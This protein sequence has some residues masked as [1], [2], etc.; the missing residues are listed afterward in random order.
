MINHAL[1][2]NLGDKRNYREDLKKMA[3]LGFEYVDFSGNLFYKGDSKLFYEE[4]KNKFYQIA[5][6]VEDSGVR[7]YSVHLL[8]S[9]F[10]PLEESPD[11]VIQ[12]NKKLIELASIM[13]PKCVTTHICA[14]PDLTEVIEKISCQQ[15]DAKVIPVY[16]ELCHYASQY[17]ITLTIENI[18]ELNYARCRRWK[19]GLDSYAVTMSDLRRLINIIDEPNLGIC[20][21]SGHAYINGISP[22]EAIL[23]AGDLLRQTH[24]N[25]NFGLTGNGMGDSD[26]HLPPGLGT[27]NWLE[28][29]A[30]LNQISY[31][32]PIMFET[33]GYRKCG[34]FEDALVLIKE[35]WKAFVRLYES[36]TQRT[37][38][39]N[40]GESYEK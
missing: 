21:D 33:G 7:V 20:L 13:K 2:I 37:S 6:W 40:H 9:T 32:N 27:I 28:V 31:S 3:D 1:G 30:A 8:H 5:Q 36:I 35:N 25:D 14:S 39:L 15:F 26:L 4:D 22:G 11:E 16:K 23:Q 34:G 24:F 29:I 12:R 17:D 38:L 10:F 19:Y 18:G